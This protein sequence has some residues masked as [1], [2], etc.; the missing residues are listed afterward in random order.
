[1][2]RTITAAQLR[3]LNPSRK[4]LER[5][6]EQQGW[7]GICRLFPGLEQQAEDILMDVDYLDQL[8]VVDTVSWLRDE[9]RPAAYYAEY[10][11]KHR[12]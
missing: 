6:L 12:A 8:D 7:S 5:L 1:M 9:L 2:T 11:R 3:R 4:Q 10:V